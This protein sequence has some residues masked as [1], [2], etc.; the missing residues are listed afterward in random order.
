MQVVSWNIGSLG[1]RACLGRSQQAARRVGL[2]FTPKQQDPPGWLL[3]P[4]LPTQVPRD[5]W[6]GASEQ[7]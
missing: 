2:A 3:C 7:P 6:W 1:V 5:S 4:Q